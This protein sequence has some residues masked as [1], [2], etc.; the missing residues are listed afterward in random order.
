MSDTLRAS[1]PDWLSLLFMFRSVLRDPRS[2]SWFEGFK[3]FYSAHSLSSPSCFCI[4]TLSSSCFRSS[5]LLSADHV[6]CDQTSVEA[7]CLGSAAALWHVTSLC[8]GRWSSNLQMKPDDDDWTAKWV[9]KPVLLILCLLHLSR[10]F[11]AGKCTNQQLTSARP[12]L[13]SF[14]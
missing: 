9:I 10:L 7:D 13:C 8:E 11:L 1:D 2:V 4:T 6:R 5:P 14:L 3:R 12:P